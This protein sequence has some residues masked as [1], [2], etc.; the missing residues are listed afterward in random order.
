MYYGERRDTC[1]VWRR[2]AFGIVLC[3]RRRT[4]TPRTKFLCISLLPFFLTE[5]FQPVRDHQRVFRVGLNLAGVAPAV[6]DT[7][8]P[9]VE[10]V[11]YEID[12][13]VTLNLEERDTRVYGFGHVFAF[14]YSLLTCMS[15]AVNTLV[16]FFQ[17]RIMGPRSL[18]LQGSV[19]SSPIRRRKTLRGREERESCYA[20][21]EVGKLVLFPSARPQ[22]RCSLGWISSHLWLAE[23]L[24]LRHVGVQRRQEAVGLTC[25]KAGEKQS[26]Q[27]A[28]NYD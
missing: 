11:A 18:T 20:P 27:Q 1:L 26:A 3:G 2:E 19:T 23:H 17:S 13:L 22:C 25:K 4:N 28:K 24:G 10:V 15:P 5:Y 9:D 7:D 14:I 16:P 21:R 12:P 6:V 8:R